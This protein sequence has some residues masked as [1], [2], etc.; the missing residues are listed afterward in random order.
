M[1]EKKEEIYAKLEFRIFK[2]NVCDSPF[3]VVHSVHGDAVLQHICDGSIY[4]FF[5]QTDS[6]VCE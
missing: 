2:E 6:K 4:G 5:V 3:V 1:N